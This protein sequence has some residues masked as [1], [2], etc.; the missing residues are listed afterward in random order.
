MNF[1]RATNGFAMIALADVSGEGRG[2][3]AAFVESGQR[4]FVSHPASGHDDDAV[5]DIRQ[6]RQ[7]GRDHHDGGAVFG[8]RLDLMTTP[9]EENGEQGGSLSAA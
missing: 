8:E 6:F 4:Y 5:R 7:L 9:C 3:D 1:G 2:E